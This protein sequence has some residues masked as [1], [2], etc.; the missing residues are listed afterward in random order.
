MGKDHLFF[1]IHLQLR[2]LS[3]FALKQQD[4]AKDTTEVIFI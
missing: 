4:N 2:A 1:V 3:I